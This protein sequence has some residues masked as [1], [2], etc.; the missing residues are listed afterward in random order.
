MQLRIDTLEAQLAALTGQPVPSSSGSFFDGQTADPQSILDPSAP[1]T[2]DSTSTTPAMTSLSLVANHAAKNGA[3]GGSGVS[4]TGLGPTSMS[5][6]EGSQPQ[7]STPNL[8]GLDTFQGGLA[9]NAH[10]ELRFYVCFPSPLWHS[11]TSL[12]TRTV[13]AQ[14]PTSSYRAVLADSTSLL[15]TPTTVNAIRAFSLTRAP[16]PT[17]SPAD[18]ALP[19]RPPDLSPDFKVKLLNL[20]FEYCFSHCTSRQFLARAGRRWL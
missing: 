17:A 4:P 11:L 19:R 9:I 18:P 8:N 15:N 13:S 20:A 3:A 14:G 12:L 7:V 6:A 10:G 5:F 1:A 16:I 2:S